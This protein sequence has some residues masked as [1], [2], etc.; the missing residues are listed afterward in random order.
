MSDNA[1]SVAIGWAW[2]GPTFPPLPI[3][4]RLR[5]R[6]SQPMF[7]PRHCRRCLETDYTLS[8]RLIDGGDA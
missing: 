5:H 6:W 8:L 2:N 3:L 1:E 7:G 4:C